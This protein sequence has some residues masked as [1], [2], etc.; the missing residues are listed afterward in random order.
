MPTLD[1]DHAIVRHALEKAGWTITH[2]PLKLELEGKRVYVDLGAERL[3]GAEKGTEKIA[4]EIKMF[5]NPSE[6]ADLEG[7]V[8]QYVFY[9][10]LLRRLEPERKIYLA[11]PDSVIQSLFRR[12]IAEGFLTDEKGLVFGFDAEKEEI[13]T[14]L[15]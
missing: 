10:W 2:D 15:P 9:R 8:G 7:A 5:T 13:T 1:R 3:L 11:V 4:V 12:P 14:W 6:I